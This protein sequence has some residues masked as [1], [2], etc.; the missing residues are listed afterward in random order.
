M[1]KVIYHIVKHDTGWAYRVDGV[2]SE[3]YRS[4]DAARRAAERAAREQR[5]P[6]EDA[7]ISFEDADGHWHEEQ[8]HS[9]DRPDT[10]VEG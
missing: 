8:V 7:T 4:H 3:A 6:G 5:S 2:F 1:A 9:D 10:E